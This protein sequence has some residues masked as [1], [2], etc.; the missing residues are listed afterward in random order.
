MK[1]AASTSN[2]R[3]GRI[4]S[5]KT[6]A[7]VERLDELRYDAAS[8]VLLLSL[9]SIECISHVAPAL[10]FSLLLLLLR[11]MFEGRLTFAHDTVFFVII[12]MAAT[13]VLSN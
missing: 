13:I 9:S 8:A 3:E 6:Y 4:T 7:Y 10:S 2:A 11:L 12:I 5:K 1:R